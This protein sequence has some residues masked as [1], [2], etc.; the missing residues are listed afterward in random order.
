MSKTAAALSRG[1]S[2]NQLLKEFQE[3]E[4][5]YT[6]AVSNVIQAEILREDAKRK[7]DECYRRLEQAR[8]RF[9]NGMEMEGSSKSGMAKKAE[10]KL[11]SSMKAKSTSSGTKKIEVE[12]SVSNRHHKNRSK[13]DEGK[14]HEG[15]KQES[16]TFKQQ[17]DQTNGS[18]K[19]V[20]PKKMHHTDIDIQPTKASVSRRSFKKLVTIEPLA[21]DPKPVLDLCKGRSREWCEKNLDCDRLGLVRQ[22]Y[23]ATF[24][25]KTNPET[26]KLN[27]STI[28]VTDEW[29]DLVT[30]TNDI[31]ELY[32]GKT[33]ASTSTTKG[34][35]KMGKN[36]SSMQQSPAPSLRDK[37]AEALAAPQNESIALFF[38]PMKRY[39]HIYYAGHWKVQHGEMLDPPKVVKGQPRQCFLQLK[40]V[41]INPS[42]IEAMNET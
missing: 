3:A 41:G 38:A 33:V 24:G 11:K 14:V 10:T 9:S 7:K 18:K 27:V 4:K 36:A 19:T 15:K 31:Q 42:I 32:I 13:S 26:Q 25:T 30:M 37:A 6:H 34:K 29:N 40:F 1:E 12:G 16:S 20:K 17:Q 35:S 5:Q 21:G 2:L 8:V 23:K 39:G 22:F 28:L